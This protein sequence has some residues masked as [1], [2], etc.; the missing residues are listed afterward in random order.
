M[1]VHLWLTPSHAQTS[2]FGFGLIEVR[3]VC[4]KARSLCHLSI[5]LLPTRGG[6][7]ARYFSASLDAEPLQP[8]G[9]RRQC[10]STLDN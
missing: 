1:G 4:E 7:A 5:I 9:T 8:K 6:G 10:L 2:G 3:V